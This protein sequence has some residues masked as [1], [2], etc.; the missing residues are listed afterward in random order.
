M[1]INPLK[2]QPDFKPIANH[3]LINPLTRNRP[4]KNNQIEVTLWAQFNTSSFDGINLVGFLTKNAEPISSSGCIFDIYSV[5]NDGLWAE[6]FVASVVGTLSGQKFV[7]SIPQS[8]LNPVELDGDVTLAIK[9]TLRRAS[10][11]FSKKIYVN[12]LGVYDSI[13]RLRDEVEFQFITKKDE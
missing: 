13:V 11:V 8:A 2:I 6:F 3:Q 7:A 10:T 9:M 4:A 1:L 12:H 5:S